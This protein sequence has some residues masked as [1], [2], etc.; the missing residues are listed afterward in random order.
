MSNPVRCCAPDRVRRR[1]SARSAGG[2]PLPAAATQPILAVAAGAAALSGPLPERGNER[3]SLLGPPAAPASRGCARLLR[4]APAPWVPGPLLR[5]F[6]FAAAA[7]PRFRGGHVGFGAGQEA[8]NAAASR[9]AQARE[10]MFDPVPVLKLFN[11]MGSGTWLATEFYD[12]GDTLFGLADLGFAVPSLA[13]S[14]CPRSRAYVRR[15]ASGS[16]AT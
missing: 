12:D 4:F 1:L 2:Q 9:A 5:A 8:G 15:S 16:S 7:H 13:C 6:P 11:P 10:G 3:R 14:A